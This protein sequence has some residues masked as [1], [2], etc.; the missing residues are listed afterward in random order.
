MAAQ[1]ARRG[2][3]AQQSYPGERI[4]LL[5]SRPMRRFVE[6]ARAADAKYR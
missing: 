2:D 6:A 1:H 5:T 4:P 3:M